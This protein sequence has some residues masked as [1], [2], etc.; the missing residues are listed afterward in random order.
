[1]SGLNIH[2]EDRDALSVELIEELIGWI[3]SRT[4]FIHVRYGDGEFRSIVG[5]RRPSNSDHCH[6]F[7]DTLGVALKDVLLGVAKSEDKT[8]IRIGGW[9]DE[10]FVGFLR[11]HDLIDRVPWCSAGAFY[12]G[13]E[14][15]QTLKLIRALDADSRKKVIVG[16]A[17][18]RPA[19]AVINAEFIEI[20]LTDC[21]LDYL[22][23]R[24]RCIQAV[25]PGA[26]FIYSAGFVSNVLGWDLWNMFPGT[27]HLDMGHVF[28]ACCGY[29]T[30]KYIRGHTKARRIL[31]KHYEPL[32]D[33]GRKLQEQGATDG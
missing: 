22:N 20:P 27:T 16:S 7:T 26:V 4:P 15:L 25:E 5:D 14:T 30:R 12:F 33:A 10:R 11:E 6:F 18:V 19:A 24:R 3:E 31:K 17:R 13:I 1:M 21:W 9:W 8:G 32:F 2:C 23:I 28:D 29:R